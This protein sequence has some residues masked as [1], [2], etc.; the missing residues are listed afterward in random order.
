MRVDGFPDDQISDALAFVR[1]CFETGR[2]G[3]P[4]SAVAGRMSTARQE[5][6][7]K[8]FPVSD[9]KFWMFLQRNGAYD[10]EPA[11]CQVQCPVYAIFGAADVIVPVARSV[12]VFGRA[13][14]R[15]PRPQFTIRVFPDASHDLSVEENGQWVPAPH[16]LDS[17]SA[18]ISQAIASPGE[19][20]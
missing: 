11:L 8:Y 1:S 17:M 9:E 3:E 19:L 18:W 14:M 6:W 7:F 4:F 12:E 5:P 13:L 20:Q 15:A 2:R 10:P 16:Y